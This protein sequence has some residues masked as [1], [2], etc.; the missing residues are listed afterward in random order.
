MAWAVTFCRALIVVHGVK[1]SQRGEIIIANKQGGKSKG[2]RR[3]IKPRA[4]LHA[5]SYKL[6]GWVSFQ[7]DTACHI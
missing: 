1:F 3:H 4:H 7:N 5:I 2:N 6:F